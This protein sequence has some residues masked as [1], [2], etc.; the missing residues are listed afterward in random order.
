MRSD[1]DYTPTEARHSLFCHVRTAVIEGTTPTEA[2]NSLFC[3]VH[4]TIMEGTTVTDQVPAGDVQTRRTV[5]L[6]EQWRQACWPLDLGRSA[7]LFTT[8]GAHPPP[9]LPRPPPPHL[10]PPPPPPTAAHHHIHTY[11]YPSLPVEHRPSTTPRHRTL[12]WAALVIPDQSSPEQS[13]TYTHTPKNP[14]LSSILKIWPHDEAV[15]NQRSW[16]RLRVTHKTP[17]HDLNRRQPMSQ[18][19]PPPSM[20]RQRVW[21]DLTRTVSAQIR[22][23]KLQKT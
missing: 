16:L 18:Q 7:S 10:P 19:D 4:A 23:I 14:H 9:L 12:F 8:M 13:A 1:R 15:Y 2:R 5:I 20:G 11:L 22:T 17:Q 21:S 6:G 3:R